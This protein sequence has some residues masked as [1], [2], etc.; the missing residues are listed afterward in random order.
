M[1]QF[2]AASI[3]LVFLAVAAASGQGVGKI[4]GTV[5]NTETKPIANAT[6][7]ITGTNY[8]ART[9]P[10]GRYAI[11][12]I[13]AGTVQVEARMIGYKPRALA[14]LRIPSGQ[15]IS[16]LDFILD[17]APVVLTQ[18]PDRFGMLLRFQLIKATATKR[19]DPGI[20]SI[21]SV[22]KDLFRFPGYKLMS[23][24]AVAVDYMSPARGSSTDQVLDGD[25]A[26]YHLTVTIDTATSRDV[27][28]RV[29]LY[30][31]LVPVTTKT[32]SGGTSISPD[33]RTM[34]STTVSIAYGR[35]VVLGSTQPGKP[36]RAGAPAQ[37]L[38]LAVKPELRQP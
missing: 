34:L 29:W 18:M 27:R 26:Q 38:I 23:T 31:T 8:S 2:L 13:P 16:R 30:E 25:G 19:S 14:G 12:G 28:L 4:E 33:R 5:T 22:L 15:T 35:T 36:G 11:D 1:R 24:A 37:T 6:I 3:A 9:G 10:D 17:N 32:A 21:D 7:M 20:A